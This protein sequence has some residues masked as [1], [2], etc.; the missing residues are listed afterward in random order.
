VHRKPP[1]TPTKG[2]GNTFYTPTKKQQKPYQISP[3]YSQPGF[4]EHHVKR[5]PRHTP[6]PYHSP[7][8]PYGCGGSL[9]FFQDCYGNS[10]MVPLGTCD[11]RNHGNVNTM[12][13]ERPPVR[14]KLFQP[15]GSG[16]MPPAPPGFE[17][18]QSIQQTNHYGGMPP[19][20]LSFEG[21]QPIQQTNHYGGMPPV[22]PMAYPGSPRDPPIPP[23][24]S[25]SYSPTYY[26]HPATRGSNRKY[27]D[28]E[29]QK[30]KM[31]MKLIE[32]KIAK[33]EKKIKLIQSKI[34]K[35]M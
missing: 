16:G 19:V 18:G 1:Q 11:H 7:F 14:R 9:S 6:G 25:P 29:F 4:L 20:P 28:S 10:Y 23:D 22:T 21:G 33:Y 32:S 30:K 13:I 17:G 35:F 15:P 12:H 5:H 2:R 8:N 3:K 31:R 27:S 26:P 34:E 24:Y